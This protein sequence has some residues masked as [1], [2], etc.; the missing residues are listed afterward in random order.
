MKWIAYLCSSLCL[1]AVQSVIAAVPVTMSGPSSAIAS[2]YNAGDSNIFTYTITNNV[3]N[4]SFP[5]TVS[6]ISGP[7]SR[8][9]VTNDCGSNLPIGPSTCFIGMLIA[10][11]AKDSN[12]SFNQTLLINYQG[13]VPLMSDIAFS[14]GSAGPVLTVAGQDLTGSSPPLLADSTDGGNTWAVI[15]V[16]GLPASGHFQAASCTGSGSTAVCTAVGTDATGSSPPL[17]AVSTNGGNTWA[18]KSVAGLPVTGDFLSTSC[19]GSGSTAICTA[20]GIENIGSHFPILAVSTNGGNTWTVKSVTGFPTNGYFLATSCTGSGSTATCAAA[21]I[22]DTAGSL[23][24]LA[25]STDG[26]NT[27]AV[28]SV[29]GIP[30]NGYFQAASCTGSGSTAVCIATGQDSTG[31]SP[32]LLADSTDGG[33]TWAV[34]SVTGLPTNG[35]FTAANCIGSGSS[36]ICTAAGA[37]NT[38]SSPPLLADST[39][40]GNTWAVKSV[41]GL[42]T[43][44][45]FSATSCTGNG[46]TAICTAVGDDFTGS[47]PPFLAISTDGGNSWAVKSVTGL[48][49]VG[50]FQAA[51]CTG[52]MSTAICTAVGINSVDTSPLLAISTDGTSNWVVK[53]VA[54]IL[55]SGYYNGAAATGGS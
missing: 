18:V 41:T 34:K 32:P 42:P 53:S 38:G 22:D 23:P 25:I 13:R 19:T 6:G 16:S 36:A 21:G 7:A 51:S 45:I 44:G 11:Q 33:N 55:G 27:W 54:G 39:D 12:K 28:K 47:A 8:T 48:P 43:S 9:T 4:K 3:P 35:D 29:T 31:S 52:S 26:G 37:D 20:V 24:V 50:N 40:G 49:A 14:V 17:L 10:P 5:I 15:S 2:S 46:S 30:A 1:F